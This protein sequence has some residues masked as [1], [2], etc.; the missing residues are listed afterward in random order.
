MATRRPVPVKGAEVLDEVSARFTL[1]LV[2]PPGAAD[3][4]ALWALAGILIGFPAE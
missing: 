1:N 4:M 3:A 2:L